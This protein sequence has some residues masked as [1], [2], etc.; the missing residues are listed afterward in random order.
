MDWLDNIKIGK[1][2]IGS[3]LIIAILLGVVAVVGY[4][5][6]KNINLRIIALEYD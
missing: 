5:E 4:V 2:L 1:K 3:F 6:M